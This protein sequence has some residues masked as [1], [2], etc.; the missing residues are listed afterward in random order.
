METGSFVRY[1]RSTQKNN[2][3]TIRLTILCLV[4]FHP[5]FS[6]QPSEKEIRDA[7]IE[8]IADALFEPQSPLVRSQHK[9]FERRNQ[10]KLQFTVEDASL[11]KLGGL[12]EHLFK[13]YKTIISPV[14]VNARTIT[15]EFSLLNEGVL[16]DLVKYRSAATAD[17]RS[18]QLPLAQTDKMDSLYTW[19]LS[20][21]SLDAGYL[22]DVPQ[23]IDELLVQAGNRYEEIIASNPDCDDLAKETYDSFVHNSTASRA[24][25]WENDVT[26]IRA[27]LSLKLGL[28]SNENIT[29][30]PVNNGNSGVAVNINPS[31]FKGS[32]IVNLNNS[33]NACTERDM[34]M[35][36]RMLFEKTGI[37]FIFLTHSISYFI[38]R[39]SL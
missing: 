33:V 37:R 35:R 24:T 15:G 14:N 8:L 18:C 2:M 10:I 11:D 21:Q 6:Q 5:A 30:A 1:I 25:N 17:L 13:I 22:N 12:S 38:P 39:D 16:S 26:F 23:S 27:Q 29:V 3:R 34:E 36:C 31:H 4:L 19:G 7:A 20:Q 9:A 32:Y 28:L